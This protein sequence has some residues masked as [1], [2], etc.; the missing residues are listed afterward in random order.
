MTSIVPFFFLT[1]I[2]IM[3]IAMLYLTVEIALDPDGEGQTWVIYPAV[4]R[5]LQRLK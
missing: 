5:F 1:W 4:R 2:A 3:F